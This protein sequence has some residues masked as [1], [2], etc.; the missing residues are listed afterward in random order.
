MNQ[1]NLAG[2]VMNGLTNKPDPGVSV[3]LPDGQI[4]SHGPRGGIL[5]DNVVAQSAPLSDAVTGAHKYRPTAVPGLQNELP[6]HTM[7]AYMLIAGRTN[8][9]IAGAAGVTPEHVSYL[10]GQ[11]WF[12]QRLAQIANNDGEEILASFKSH[13]LAAVERIAQIA[14]SGESERNRL[15]ANTYLVDQAV[16]KAVQKNLTI[17]GNVLSGLSPQEEYSRTQEELR[18]LREARNP[19]P[20]PSSTPRR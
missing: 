2:E 12:Q 1:V 16:G 15:S 17:S 14:E 13:A 20:V 5:R 10:R 3:Q 8:T 6:W 18:L 11:L 4:Y 7:A 19:R 9:E